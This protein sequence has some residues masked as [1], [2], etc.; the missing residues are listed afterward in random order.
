MKSKETEKRVLEAITNYK[1]EHGYSPTIRELCELSGLK[2]TSSV[3]YVLCNLEKQGYITNE[4]GKC[5]AIKVVRV[6]E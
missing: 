4:Q 1:A 5:R 3:H 2:S 6:I